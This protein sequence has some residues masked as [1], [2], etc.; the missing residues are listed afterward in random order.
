MIGVITASKTSGSV[1]GYDFGDMKEKDQKI[2]ILASEGVIMDPLLIERL[3]QNWTDDASK[4]VFKYISRAVADDLSKQFDAQASLSDRI[5]R[6]TGH[7]A[8]SFPEGDRERLLDDNF[9]LQIASEYME[10]M[11][12]TDTQ[13]VLTAHLPTP[14]NPEL[15][16][17]IHLAYNRVRYD[18][19]VIDSGNERYRSQKIAEEI[20]KKYNLTPAGVEKRREKALISEQQLYSQMRTLAK[21]AL[22]ESCTMDEFKFNLR[23]RGIE[24]CLS[25]HS[26]Q[27]KSYGISYAMGE[28]SAKGSKLDRSALS[29]TKVYNT[30]ANNLA[31]RIDLEIKAKEEELQKRARL[32]VEQAN[33]A[34]D[35]KNTYNTMF[36]TIKE[37]GNTVNKTYE[38]FRE[39]KDAGVAI[40]ALTTG[41]YNELRDTWHQFC[42]QSREIKNAKT[43]GAMIKTLGGMLV[44]LNPVVGLLVMVIGSIATDIRLS[45]IRHDKKVLLSKIE[46]LKNDIDALKQQKSEIKIETQERLK[47][48]LQAKDARN[49]FRQGMN[50]IKAEIDAL[51]EQTTKKEVT[52]DDLAKAL[53]Q[54]QKTNPGTPQANT[55]KK[56]VVVNPNLD[57]RI[58]GSLGRKNITE[59]KQA[60]M[61]N[62][63]VLKPVLRQDGAITSFEILHAGR[64]YMMEDILKPS[65]ILVLMKNWERLTG[66]KSAKTV[67][68]N[69]RK[70]QPGPQRG[71]KLNENFRYNFKDILDNHEDAPEPKK[72]K[73]KGM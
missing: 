45:S 12:I 38:L 65:T 43:D 16:P 14:E 5:V 27:K 40:N 11:D 41:K 72:G 58:L 36:P 17:H 49:E 9:A 28:I 42:E 52:M 35:L 55:E 51:K 4:Q 23:K 32:Q 71:Y 50:K 24:L 30:L 54:S 64:R 37:L 70:Q 3:N 53:S 44:M 6:A 7:I 63:I 2:H 25:E 34:R 22:Q 68:S 47:D 61:Y 57:G 1:L 29:Y 56:P 19:S 10:R 60:L 59:V 69:T 26:E 20:S 15:K 18:G 67:D 73:G 39:S 66:L 46:S 48:Y 33:L 31:D 8:L 13:W 21:E 62:D